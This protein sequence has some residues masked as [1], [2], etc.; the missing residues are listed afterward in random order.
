LGGPEAPL[1]VEQTAS[2]F[3]K[4]FDTASAVQLKSSDLTKIPSNYHSFYDR[5]VHSPVAFVS[6]KGNLMSW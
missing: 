4:L 5:L 6:H 3:L 2:D 1:T